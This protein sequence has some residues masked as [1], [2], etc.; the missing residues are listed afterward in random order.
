MR[1]TSKNSAT[2]PFFVNVKNELG[3]KRFRQLVAAFHNASDREVSRTFKLEKTRVHKLRKYLKLPCYKADRKMVR[4]SVFLRYKRASDRKLS[5]ILGISQ[6]VV[7]NCRKHWGLEAR[8]KRK[9]YDWDDDS[10]QLLGTATDE[11]VGRVLGLSRGLVSKKR[12]SLRISPYGPPKPQY[13]WSDRG[14][15]M[16]GKL[17][18][19]QVARALR[20]SVDTVRLK[21]VSLCIPRFRK[22]THLRWTESVVRDLFEMTDIE[23]A[24]KYGVHRNTARWRKITYGLKSYL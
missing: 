10:L 2:P 21:R 23:F 6:F 1:V 24:R 4:K 5:K 19:R 8:H 20:I 22:Q 12:R 7:R 16:L 9:R 17:A 13:A 3:A 11:Q 14:L 15:S 18:D